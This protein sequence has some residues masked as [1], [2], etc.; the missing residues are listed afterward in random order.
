VGFSGGDVTMRA[1]FHIF[2]HLPGPGPQPIDPFL[3]LLDFLKTRPK[4][5]SIEP[6]IDLLAVPSPPGGF[7]GLS[8]PN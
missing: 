8:P 4:S 2:G 1:C 7:G 3:Y 6:L 5:A